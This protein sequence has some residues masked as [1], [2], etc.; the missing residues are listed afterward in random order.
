MDVQPWGSDERQT[1]E[2]L[3]NYRYVDHL[4]LW[5]QIGSF[6]EIHSSGG[7]KGQ[8]DDQ[9]SGVLTVKGRMIFRE[10][11]ICPI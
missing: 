11:V 1:L 8:S 10:G 4:M 2:I 5:Y 6:R 7:Q 3:R 9:M